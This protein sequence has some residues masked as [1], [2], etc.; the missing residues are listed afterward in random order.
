MH[1][2]I[3]GWRDKYADPTCQM[4]PTDVEHPSIPKQLHSMDCQDMV[5]GKAFESYSN[6][7][8]YYTRDRYSRVGTIF[9]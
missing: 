7:G 1:L 6:I 4:Y 3:L 8:D 5:I 2:P 9:Q